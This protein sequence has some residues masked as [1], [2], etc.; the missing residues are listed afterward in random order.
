[1]ISKFKLYIL[2]WV[3]LL[4]FPIPAYFA[5]HYLKDVQWESF[6]QLD[7]ITPISI[8]YG[9]EFGIIYAFIASVILK[10]L[11]LNPFL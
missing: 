2:G 9:L 5:V 6:I 7:K 10:L 4:V 3:T 1:M 11:F 8:L